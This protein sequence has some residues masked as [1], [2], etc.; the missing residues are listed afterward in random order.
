MYIEEKKRLIER[1]Y[2][3]KA[4]HVKYMNE[5]YNNHIKDTLI[6]ATT[7]LD[8]PY[9]ALY[10]KQNIIS[11]KYRRKFLLLFFCVP[12]KKE[13]YFFVFQRNISIFSVVVVV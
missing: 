6:L 11:K 8:M 10:K 7:T 2:I 1:I 5:V 12:P 4:L 13:E 9:N 3:S